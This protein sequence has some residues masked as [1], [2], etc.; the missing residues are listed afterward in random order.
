M[1][2]PKHRNLF[3][4]YAALAA[5]MMALFF[6]ACVEPGVPN[7][8]RFRVAMVMIFCAF[9]STLM[10]HEWRADAEGERTKGKP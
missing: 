9:A 4:V 2:G 3:L 10:W 6:R 7:S 5:V 1:N 8:D